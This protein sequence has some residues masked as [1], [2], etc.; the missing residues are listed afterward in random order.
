MQSLNHNNISNNQYII[1]LAAIGE[2]ERRHMSGAAIRTFA[3]ISD[4]WNLTEKQRLILLGAPGRSTYYSWLSKASLNHDIVLPLDVLLRISAILGIHKA[5]N[6]IFHSKEHG[7]K[8]LSNPNSGT[9]FGGQSPKEIMLAGTQDSILTIRRYLDAWRGG[10]FSSPDVKDDE[11]F[12][13]PSD[14]VIIKKG[15]GSKG[16]KD[17]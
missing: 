15:D 14:V 10:V 17:V 16:D 12:V 2:S 5:I 11:N 13:L 9:L 1:D 3:N 6:I 7:L 8:W 4:L